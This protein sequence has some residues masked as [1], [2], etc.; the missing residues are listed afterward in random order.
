MKIKKEFSSV[1]E[2]KKML[3]KERERLDFISRMIKYYTDEWVDSQTKIIDI[4]ETIDK[5]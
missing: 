5:L 2:L 1:R 3:D 4:Q